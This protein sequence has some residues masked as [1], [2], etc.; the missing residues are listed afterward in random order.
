[1]TNPRVL[2]TGGAGFV[3]SHL[4]ERLLRDGFDVVA[5]DDLSTGRLANIEHLLAHP[6]FSFVEGSVLDEDLVRRQTAWC[7][8][9]AHLA[10]AVGVRL[11]VEQTLRSLF[12]NLRGT[13][14]VLEAAA[15]RGR[16]MLFASTSEVYGKRG[17]DRLREDDDGVFGSPAVARWSYALAKAADEAL[18]FAYHRELGLDVRVVRLFNTV[19]PRQV[20]AYGM[21][22]P[23]FARA[24]V[25]DAPLVVHGDGLQTRTFCHVSDAVEAMMLLIGEPTAAG[26]AFNVGGR[27]EVSILELAQRVAAA[28]GSASPIRFVPYEDV[29]G[30]GFEDV[31]RRVPDTTRIERLCGWT[32]RLTLG[33]I[34]SDVVE[35]ARGLAPAAMRPDVV[36]KAG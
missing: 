10:A 3:G 12:A 26:A 5:V 2:V 31:R 18:A 32:P 23:R 33:A 27:E 7:D 34:V 25:R 30:D 35:D 15:R 24:A 19:G 1:M 20:G 9:V 14:I 13:E 11:I 21:V 4:A 22:L 6:R 8:V 36:S 28:A 29:Y 17:G 16:R